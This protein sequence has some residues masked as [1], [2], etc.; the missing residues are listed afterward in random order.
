M[1]LLAHSNNLMRISSIAVMLVISCAGCSSY[2]VDITDPTPEQLAESFVAAVQEQNQHKLAQLIHPLCKMN[3]SPLEQ[4]YIDYVIM[5]DLS[6]HIPL[7]APMSIHDLKGWKPPEPN[8][9][10]R[11][12]I[13]PT[14]QIDIEIKTEEYSSIS[15][16]HY[17][18]QDKG[19]WFIVIPVPNK[20]TLEL[21]EKKVF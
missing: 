15:I 11:W 16:G 21:Y 3:L 10:P 8:N 1:N 14:H 4:K 7:N 12:P 18:V 20:E 13:T 2:T 19:N 9:D 6:H 17:I 5:K